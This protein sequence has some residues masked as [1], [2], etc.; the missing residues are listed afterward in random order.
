[1]PPRRQ[2][3][4]TTEALAVT[5][6]ATAVASVPVPVISQFMTFLL[7]DTL[8]LNDNDNS[9]KKQFALAMTP[10]AIFAFTAAVCGVT[11]LKRTSENRWVG[12][13]ALA[14]A[15]LGIMIFLLLAA[16]VVVFLTTDPSPPNLDGF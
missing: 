10:V 2:P 13:L 11:A 3:L 14:G 16:G 5:S 6:P 4:V 12:A 9:Q 15:T 8:G 7:A 1:V